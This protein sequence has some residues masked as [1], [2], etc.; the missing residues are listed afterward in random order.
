MLK[1]LAAPACAGKKVFIGFSVHND[2][3]SDDDGARWTGKLFFQRPMHSL[4]GHV[5]G[6]WRSEKILRRR[7]AWSDNCGTAMAANRAL[8]EISWERSRFRFD[9]DR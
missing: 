4:I 2:L 9:M 6:R 8:T 7:R 1:K 5:N 3:S